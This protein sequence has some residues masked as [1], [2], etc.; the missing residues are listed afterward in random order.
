METEN[1]LLTVLPINNEE[2]EDDYKARRMSSSLQSLEVMQPEEKEDDE[3]IPESLS[4]GIFDF[5]EN[6][7]GF[8]P[9][10]YICYDIS[11]HRNWLFKLYKKSNSVWFCLV[12]SFFNNKCICYL[13][14]FGGND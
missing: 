12:W 9:W 8:S 11:F 10:V 5:W 14:V 3:D 2:D 4:R 7:S 1:N 13:L 6:E